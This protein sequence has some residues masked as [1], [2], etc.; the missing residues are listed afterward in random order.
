MDRTKENVLWEIVKL[1]DISLSIF[2]LY[3]KK[4]AKSEK[5]LSNVIWLHKFSWPRLVSFQEKVKYIFF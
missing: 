5:N 1:L 4:I 2:P 3:Y